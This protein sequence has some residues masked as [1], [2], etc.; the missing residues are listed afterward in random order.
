MPHFLECANSN[1]IA[2]TICAR[3]AYSTSKKLHSK[4][5]WLLQV[6]QNLN[7]NVLQKYG[8]T[9]ENDRRRLCT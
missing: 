5:F 7:L 3:K 1:G 9:K 8:K 4:M 2:C 6:S